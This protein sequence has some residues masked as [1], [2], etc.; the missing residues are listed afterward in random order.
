MIRVPA[1]GSRRARGSS[2]SGLDP[3]GGLD[4]Q[5]A[6]TSHTGDVVGRHPVEQVDHHVADQR[7]RADRHGGGRDPASTSTPGRDAEH[8]AAGPEHGGR[9]DQNAGTSSS[10]PAIA[11]PSPMRAERPAYPGMTSRQQ[12]PGARRRARGG[13]DR[14]APPEGGHRPGDRDPAEPARSSSRTPE[15]RLTAANRVVAEGGSLFA[16]SVTRRL[17]EEFACHGPQTTMSP[18]C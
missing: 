12:R 13:A 18:G 6:V 11:R 17:I 14:R 3:M 2:M 8:D 15:E 7:Q 5:L 10:S 9:P 4:R 1:T 16:P